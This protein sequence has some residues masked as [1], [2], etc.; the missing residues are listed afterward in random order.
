MLNKRERFSLLTLFR[1]VTALQ[2]D[3][4][5]IK[6]FGGFSIRWG[7]AEISDSSN[8]MLKIWLLLAYLIYRRGQAV[9]QNDLISLL[10]E[11]SEEQSNAPGSLKT[12]LYRARTM[13]DSLRPGA[14]HLLIRRSGAAYTWNT[15]IPL[16]L[17]ALEFDRLFALFE[18]ADEEE[19]LSLGRQALALYT[20][21]F[22]DRLS[23]ENWVVP[24][25][26][27][28]H[29]LFLRLTEDTL[30]LLEQR[31]LWEE[32]ESVSHQ[33]LRLEPY[34]EEL[35]CHRMKALLA[36]GDHAGAAAVYEEMSELLFS[37]FGVKPSEEAIALYRKARG[38]V[39]DH[40]IPVGDVHE[41]LKEQDRT[42]GALYCE[43]DY[44]KT[45]YRLTARSIA[46]SGDSVH[47]AVLTIQ[48]RNGAL[49]RR[50]LDK[51][52][53]NLKVVAVE[54]LRQG[55][56]VSQCSLS[57]FVLLLPQANYENSCMVCA[58]ILR[59]FARKYPHSPA[60]LHFNVQPLEPRDLRD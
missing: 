35:Y 1:E 50:S 36:R 40:S 15:D 18:K 5:Q 8:R 10:W 28:Y 41:L 48:G 29:R 21:G 25:A 59:N 3:T 45:L 55:D 2:S 30:S 13:L 53:E 31:S 14:G 27:Y 54:S 58:R 23:M 51:A 38:A 32:S 52:A 16:E 4:L 12:M 46:R 42:K 56:V 7:D 19:K 49:S 39:S 34:S 6:M 11:N 17:D 20:G 60:N 26:A 22:L 44:F 43:Y 57:Q 24:I 47:L 37:T 9:T 33:A